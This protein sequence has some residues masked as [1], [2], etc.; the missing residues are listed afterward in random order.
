MSR[1]SILVRCVV[2]LSLIGLMLYS[3]I[4]AA[5]ATYLSDDSAQYVIKSTLEKNGFI[6]VSTRIGDG[7]ANGGEKALIL[8]YR[9]SATTSSDLMSETAKILGAFVGAVK[10]GWDCDSL[11]T[12]VG[13]Q[14]GGTAGTWYCK[15]EWKDE[16]LQGYLT[17]TDIC[18]KVLGTMQSF[19]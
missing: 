5:S 12:V 4:P 2:V 7:R 6:D 18:L 1:L 19:S 15:K 9:S 14:S 10:A 11:M 3:E 8:A 17:D 16:Y 13:T